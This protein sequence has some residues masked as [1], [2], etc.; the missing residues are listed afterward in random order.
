MRRNDEKRLE[1][2]LVLIPEEERAAWIQE[3]K[4]L[5]RIVDSYGRIEKKRHWNASLG[6][7]E[8]VAEVS[9]L[10]NEARCADRVIIRRQH[11]RAMAPSGFTLDRWHRE[12]QRAGVATTIRETE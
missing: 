10:Y 9:S 5:G 8:F 7:Y 3:A 12:Y 11:H 4:R 6:K 1:E 2:A